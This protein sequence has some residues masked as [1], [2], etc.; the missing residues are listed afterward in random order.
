MAVPDRPCRIMNLCTYWSSSASRV[1]GR[2]HDR[3]NTDAF[4]KFSASVF[5]ILEVS[6]TSCGRAAIRPD[7]R[8]T[9]KKECYD[10]D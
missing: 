9:I 6:S 3:K 10:T 7:E 8:V 5:G 4:G 2:T 1:K